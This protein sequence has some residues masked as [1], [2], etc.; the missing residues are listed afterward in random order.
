MYKFYSFTSILMVLMM[1][2][3]VT[4]F[5]Q[6]Y[7]VKQVITGNSG[8]FEAAP[9]Y[10]DWVTL[11]QYNPVNQTSDLFGTIFTQ[12]VQDIL[13]VG[14]FAYVTAQD[15]IAK[16]NL[17]TMEQIA[18]VADSGLNKLALCNG[19]LV[20]SKQ[21]PLT[22]NFVVIR[23]TADL[24]LV[25][26]IGG[27]SGDCMGIVTMGDSLYVAVNGGWA[28]TEGKL[29]VIDP[30][31]W[32]L[33][34]EANF[35]TSAVG[36]AQLYLSGETIISVNKT[37]WGTTPPAGSI[38]WYTP[39]TGA[40]FTKMFDVTVGNG[41]GLHDGLL[42]VLMN[43]AIG[44]ID[45]TTKEIV[46][47]VVVA[48]PGSAMFTYITAATVDTINDRIYTNIGDY[49]MPGR[50]LVT[51]LAGDSITEYTTGISSEVVV[52]EYR[53]N[54]TAIDEPLATISAADFTVYPN[55]ATDK[56]TVRTNS[57]NPVTSLS[58]QTISGKIIWQQTYSQQILGEIQV[59]LGTL[60]SG[61][62]LLRIDSQGIPV[63]K[64]VVKQ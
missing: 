15:S 31:D 59:D 55:P 8:K 3:S 2:W 34:R 5:G 27:I 14:H 52:I 54:M 58:L 20:V 12:S 35:G 60:P 36:I 37:P 4:L 32:S 7:H 47:S 1:A 19:K 18:I 39:Q 30:A 44:T 40:S 9:P 13:I 48:D 45:I 26:E 57:S 56:I 53:E 16:Y 23:D 63:V 51:N 50:C 46:D 29:A 38:T 10:T 62:Y 42:Y 24:S 21:F 6:G 64:K 43:E 61:I 25:Q 28:G 49:V 33:V 41:F 17:N 22:Q 11:Q